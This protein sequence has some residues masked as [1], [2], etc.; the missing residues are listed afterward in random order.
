MKCTLT[1]DSQ[2]VRYFKIFII[3]WVK[4]I[5]FVQNIISKIITLHQEDQILVRVAQNSEISTRRLSA[6]VGIN[7]PYVI[8]ILHKKTVYPFHFTPVQSL[9][10]R[11]YRIRLEFCQLLKR[12]L[13]NNP[14]FLNTI[15]LT[16]EAT[17]TRR[18]VFD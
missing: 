13:N 8:R 3:N 7:Q 17:F 15:L 6:A 9:L 2:T 14:T 11:D 18:R 4:Q 12:K 5:H 10:P 1:K 16:D